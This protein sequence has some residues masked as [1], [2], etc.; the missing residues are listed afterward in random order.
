MGISS[1]CA[2][3]MYE[4]RVLSDG[5]PDIGAREVAA[6]VSDSKVPSDPL[7]DIVACVSRAVG[8]PRVRSAAIIGCGPVPHA[9]V[10]LQGL[11]WRAVGIEPVPAFVAA[12]RHLVGQ[13]EDIVK[14]SAEETTLESE[15]Q[16]LVVMQNVLEHVDS[17][18]KALGEAYRILLPGGVLF[19]TTTNR[20]E[21]TNDEY[22]VRFYQWL[23]R[24]LQEAYVHQHLHFEPRLARH[25]SRPAVHWFTYAQLCGLGRSVGF[26]RFYS[27]LDL[28]DK[29]DGAIRGRPLREFLLNKVRYNPWLR[30]AVLTQKGGSIFMLKRQVV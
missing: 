1:G 18:L 25:T 15:S 27:K 12:A 11:G 21:I 6:K 19:V 30:S 23:P 24:L 8:L 16:S 17:P 14:A 9:V 2:R 5:H 29:D 26:Y 13:P 20:L 7:A 4:T 3:Q 10:E 22:T 28:L